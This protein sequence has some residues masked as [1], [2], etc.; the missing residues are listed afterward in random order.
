[1]ERDLRLTAKLGRTPACDEC[2]EAAAFDLPAG[3]R[4][5]RRHELRHSYASMGAGQNESLHVI[6]ALLSH[7]DTATAQRYAHLSDDPVRA[8]ADR[9]SGRLAAAMAGKP[10]AAVPL[11]PD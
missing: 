4:D 3:L 9:M 6:G 1:M 2:R 8:A 5:V 7:R 11:H 10:G